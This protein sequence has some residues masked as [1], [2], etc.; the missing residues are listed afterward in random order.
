MLPLVQ[1]VREN[2]ARWLKLAEEKKLCI[3]TEK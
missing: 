3:C 1:G 2:R